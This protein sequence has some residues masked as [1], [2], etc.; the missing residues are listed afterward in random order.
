[1]A[2]G[3]GKTHGKG[4]VAVQP[5]CVHGKGCATATLP[6]AFVVQRVFAVRRVGSL[7]SRFLCRA[8]SSD[9]VVQGFFVVCSVQMLPCIFFLPCV[10]LGAHERLLCYA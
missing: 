1:M 7:L 10:L 3:K 5:T 6:K 8:L 9:F 4:Y 2:H